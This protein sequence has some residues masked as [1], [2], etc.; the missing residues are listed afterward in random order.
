MP[1]PGGSRRQSL[2]QS[3][4][5]SWDRHGMKKSAG[6]APKIASIPRASVTPPILCEP[7]RPNCLPCRRPSA[8]RRWRQPSSLVQYLTSKSSCMLILL[9]SRWSRLVRLSL[10]F[11]PH[12][13]YKP[14][15]V[16]NGQQVIDRLLAVPRARLDIG[17]Q[18][19]LGFFYHL[20]YAVRHAGTPLTG[21]ENARKNGV[22][23]KGRPPE[24]RRPSL[25][26]LHI[27]WKT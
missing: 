9:R 4:W 15:I 25:G 20:G 10:M 7:R 5:D 11:L 23:P 18:D 21:K 22:F 12:R 3:R 16:K 13:L 1:G 24:G 26:R 19:G 6:L 2:S 27:A 8:A 17:S 14:F